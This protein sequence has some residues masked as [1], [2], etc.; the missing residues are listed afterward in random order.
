[1][2]TYKLERALWL[3]FLGLVLAF[4]AILLIIY[5][6]ND[7][8]WNSDVIKHSK[9]KAF[10]IILYL[11]AHYL[12][13]NEYP[14]DSQFN[15][16]IKSCKLLQPTAGSRIWIYKSYDGKSFQLSFQ[17]NKGV[18]YCAYLSKDR[19]WYLAESF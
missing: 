5:N 4:V 1:M 6:S 8:Q 15:N 19:G 18:P 14:K 16:V 10:P 2:K 11:E 17:K 12:I 7:E 3:S 13:Y 9:I